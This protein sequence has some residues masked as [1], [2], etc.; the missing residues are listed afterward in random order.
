MKAREVQD[1]SDV[2]KYLLTAYSVSAS[3][4]P[5]NGDELMT[6]TTPHA[7]D[8]GNLMDADQLQQQQRQQAIND[9]RTMLDWLE[10]HPEV[11]LPYDIQFGMLI[12][13]VNT[14]DE[15]A[16]LAR[17]FGECEKEFADDHFY[18]RK[19]FGCTQLY[20]FTSRQQVCERVV[21]GTEA[22]PEEVRP[23]YIKEIVEWRCTEPLLN[24][25]DK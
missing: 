10:A 4:L 20:A 21:V 24:G 15:L 9:T 23:A 19:R 7:D 6:T 3:I 1:K 11:D 2:I 22:I 5:V 17:A 8:R 14:K 25:G 18:L 16:V 12:A 13:S